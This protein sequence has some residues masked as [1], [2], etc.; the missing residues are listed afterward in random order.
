MITYLV[1]QTIVGIIASIFFVTGAYKKGSNKYNKH[2]KQGELL[3]NIGIAI[4]VLFLAD[5]F[6]LAMLLIKPKV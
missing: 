3:I 5:L 6:A 1:I 2:D 4:I